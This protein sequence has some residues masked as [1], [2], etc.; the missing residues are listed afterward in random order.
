ME[1]MIVEIIVMKESYVK[2]PIRNITYFRYN[3]KQIN[4]ENSV[5]SI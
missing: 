5:F 1:K 2:V 4:S 3:K